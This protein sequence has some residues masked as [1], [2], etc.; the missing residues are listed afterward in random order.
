MVGVTRWG[1]ADKHCGPPAQDADG[2]EALPSQGEMPVTVQP[3]ESVSPEGVNGG[4]L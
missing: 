2:P 4:W 1:A 3:S